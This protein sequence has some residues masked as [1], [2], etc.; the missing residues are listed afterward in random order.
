[1]RRTLSI[2]ALAIIMVASPLFGA[3]NPVQ[4]DHLFDTDHFI[5]ARTLLLDELAKAGTPKEE[6]DILW[7]L[8]RVM[9]SIGDDL[10]KSDKEGRFSAYEEGEAY[11]LRSIEIHPQADGYLWKAS[12]VGRWGQTKGPLNSLAKAKGMLDDL[13]VIVNDFDTLDSSETWYVLS[14]LYDE[15]PPVISFGNNDWAIS[16]G[17]KALEHI[18][19]HLLYP[20]HYQKVASELWARNWSASKRAKEMKKM[21]KSWEK[22]TTNLERYRYYEGK[23][24]GSTIPF[25]SSVSLVKMSDRQEA[26][27]LLSYALAKYKV[28]SPIKR[29]DTREIEEIEALRSSW[30]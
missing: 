11:A 19:A 29:A 22:A 24:G 28:F 1:M 9:V 12:N 16:Y 8:S 14:A 21:E 30:I 23:D 4:A 26:E 6:S 7:R 13:T 10:D 20:G 25:Y 5:E 27:M 15:L 18:P 3:F 2:I 17:R